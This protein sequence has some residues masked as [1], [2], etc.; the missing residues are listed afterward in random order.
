MPFVPCMRKLMLYNKSPQ[1][2]VAYNIR[3]L[4]SCPWV[5]RSLWFGGSRLDSAGLGRAALLQPAHWLSLAELGWARLQAAGLPQG[6]STCLSTPLDQRH[7]FLMASGR[8]T[9]AQ[10]KLH[11]YIEGLWSSLTHYHSIDQSNTHEQTQH[12]LYKEQSSGKRWD[13]AILF[14]WSYRDQ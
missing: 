1:N 3:H 7:I 8:M 11:K 6:H 9:R 14:Q 2:S 10:T 5:C 4:F 13:C 12:L